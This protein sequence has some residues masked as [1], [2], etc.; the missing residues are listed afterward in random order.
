MKADALLAA[1]VVACAD[2]VQEGRVSARALTEAS[3]ARCAADAHGALLHVDTEGALDAADQVDAARRGGASLGALAGVPLVVK[4]NLCTRGVPTT[5]ATRLLEGWVPPYDA[6]AVTRLREAG[7][8]LVAKAN[9]DELAMGSSS[10]TSAYGPV[11]NPLDPS[12]VPGGSSGGS[13]A[14]VAAGLAP[15]AL[16]SDTGGSVRQPAA[17]C[18]VV[19]LKP[20]YGRVSRHGLIA[21]ASSFDVVGPLA[22]SV[23]DTARLLAVMAGAD[24][25]DATSADAPVDRYEPAADAGVRGMTVGVLR[26]AF[27]TADPKVAAAVLERIARLEGAGATLVDVQLPHAARAL[28]AYYLLAPAEAS[29]NLA[30]LDGMRFGPRASA[31]DLRGSYDATRARFGPEVKRRILLGTFALR[32]GYRDAL[33]GRAQRVRTLVARDYDAAFARC[34]VL[35]GPTAPTVAFPLGAFAGDP[36]AMY[37]A[38]LETLPASLAGLP[39][40]SVP[41]GA[42]DDGLPAGLQLVAPAFQESRLFAAGAAAEPA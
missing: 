26:S 19:G 21:F 3:L 25:Q 23:R 12:R 34:D 7:A 28:S 16:G 41:A 8:V 29:S 39:A 2:A 24:A 11:A 32:A 4:D 10:E 30:R 27:E 5:A 20:T 9:L 37:R 6:A 33:Y 42:A 40:I 36:M 31:R 14:A 17:F 15:G 22:R 35:A 13:A 38:D 18:G 1:G